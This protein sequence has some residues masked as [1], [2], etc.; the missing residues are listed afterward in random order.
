MKRIVLVLMI[1]LLTVPAVAQ[2]GIDLSRASFHGSPNV[3]AWPV[4]VTLRAVEF[5]PGA[6]KGVAPMFNRA[7]M[8]ARWPNVRPPG[9][10]G[11]IQF[12]LWACVRIGGWHCAGLQEFWGDHAGPP[13]VWS[14]APF[15]ETGVHGKNNWQENWAYD[16]RWGPMSGYVPMLGDEVAFFLTAGDQRNPHDIRSVEER[17]NVVK[18][19]LATQGVALPIVD[20]AVPVPPPP[21]VPVPTLPPASPAGPDYGPKIAALELAVQTLTGELAAHVTYLN[22]S[23]AWVTEQVEALAGRVSALE[24]RPVPLRC[25][26]AIALGIRIPVSCRLE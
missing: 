7:E 14:G 12:T 23:R 10:N 25:V 21:V 3:S 18:V 4:T 22:D 9:W 24:S 5:Q 8:N 2:D 26:A 16:G 15:L 6:D 1:V 17:T 13:R 20:G 11:P 19:K